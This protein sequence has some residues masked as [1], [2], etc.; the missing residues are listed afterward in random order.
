MTTGAEVSIRTA[1]TADASL[2]VAIRSC[3]RPSATLVDEFVHHLGIPSGDDYFCLT[4]EIDGVVVGYL[5]AGGS[6]DEDR[7]SYGEFYELAV[8]PA[9]ARSSALF[10]LAHEGLGRLVRAQYGGVIAWVDLLDV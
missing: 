2:L 10:D 4:G 7:K 6:R 9:H 8:D 3:R 1:G 5:S